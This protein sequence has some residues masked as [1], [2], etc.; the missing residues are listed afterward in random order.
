M[1]ALSRQGEFMTTKLPG[2][3]PSRDVR[4]PLTLAEWNAASADFRTGWLAALTATSR[5]IG[6]GLR[7]LSS[8]GVRLG[9]VS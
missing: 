1:G 3:Q 7:A 4:A 8:D 5:V 6:V 9:A 2:V